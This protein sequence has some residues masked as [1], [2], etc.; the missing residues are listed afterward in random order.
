MRTA[1]PKG[2]GGQDGPPRGAVHPLLALL[3]LFSGI[4]LLLN[5]VG[6]ID[7]RV[8]LATTLSVMVVGL[9]LVVL[10]SPSSE[11]RRLGRAIAVGAVAGFIA[12]M[13]Y[14]L[15]KAGLSVLDP[16]RYNPF[17]AIRAFGELLA[18][19]AA[20]ETAIVASGATFHLLNG[21][22]FGIAYV[23]LFAHDGAIS[24]RRALGTGVVWGVF[25]ELFQLTLYPGW[26]D[27]RTYEEFATIS[28]LGHIVYGA[29]L[30]AIARS[31][32]RSGHAR[33]VR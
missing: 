10:R 8:A 32:F 16:S 12:T 17:H 19:K 13:A 33:R 28:A 2:D 20:R 14:D 4:A 11:R 25:L 23:F 3:A 22:M 29:T 21:T 27:I 24:M 26:L 5:I 7:L 30:G 18:G 31:L 9:T 15:S 6:R 1:A